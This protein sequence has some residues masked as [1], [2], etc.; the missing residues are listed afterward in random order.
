MDVEGNCVGNPIALGKRNE[1][2][3]MGEIWIEPCACTLRVILGRVGQRC[4]CPRQF[5]RYWIQGRALGKPREGCGATAWGKQRMGL[6][7]LFD[8]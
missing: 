1:G 7:S 8:G 3:W 6:L 4:R 5:R 2:I